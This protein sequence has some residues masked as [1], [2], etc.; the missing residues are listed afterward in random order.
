LPAAG[1]NHDSEKELGEV[2]LG[3]LCSSGAEFKL[4]SYPWSLP[5]QHCI[6]LP[7]L[8]S[9]LPDP[10]LTIDLPYHYDLAGSHQTT[11]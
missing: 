1:L 5:E 3:V 10:G 2:L 6:A 9:I 7:D 11:G 8:T 4:R